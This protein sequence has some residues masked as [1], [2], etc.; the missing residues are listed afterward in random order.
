MFDPH[1]GAFMT[2]ERRPGKARRSKRVRPVPVVNPNAGGID[3][4][5]TEI[6]V[7]VPAGRDAESVRRFETFTEDL[8][9]MADWL[10]SCGVTTVAME[11]TSVYW[12]PLFFV[13][14]ERGIEVCLV[15][16]RHFRNVPGRKTDVVDC[17]WLQYLHAVGLLRGS[18]HPPEA[19]AAVRTLMRHRLSLVQM[20]SAH[21]QHMQKALTQM[22]LQLHHV[23]SDITGVSGLAILD[24]IVAGERRPTVLADLCHHRIKASKDTIAKALTGTWRAEHIFTLRQSLVAY[25]SYQSQIQECDGEMYRLLG[26]FDSRIDPHEHPLPPS[27]KGRNS[28]FDLRTELYRIIGVDLTAVPG[29]DVNTIYTLFGEC[30]SDLSA[31]PSAGHFASWLGLSPN[32]RIT[33]GKVFS[34]RT[35]KVNQRS[36]TALRIA[37]QTLFSSKSPLGDYARRMRYRLGPPKAVTAVAHKLARIIYVLVT[38]RQPYDESLFGQHERDHQERVTSRLRRQAAAM[39]FELVPVP[40]A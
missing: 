31:F 6:Y 39:G 13:L 20:A 16:A 3:V 30:G 24:A 15:N 27:R 2:Q 38:T 29:I 5:A 12:I 19:V 36:A 26:T 8:H 18:F 9:A 25:R 34:T 14:E 22:N 23:I 21:V 7:A 40:A 11:S 10:C 4:G 37:A 35:R 17:E 32:N 33:G 28:G 1:A